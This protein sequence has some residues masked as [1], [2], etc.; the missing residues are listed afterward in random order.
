MTIGKRIRRFARVGSDYAEHLGLVL[1]ILL[2]ADERFPNVLW[3]GW[4]L[5]I[6]WLI[7]T[8]LFLA[9]IY[10]AIQIKRGNAEI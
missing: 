1:V 6:L 10:D 2:L 9:M 8:P 5:T 4:G 3:I 7:V